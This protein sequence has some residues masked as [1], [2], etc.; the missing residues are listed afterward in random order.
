MDE[1]VSEDRGSNTGDKANET[2]CPLLACSVF[3]ILQICGALREKVKKD[4]VAAHSA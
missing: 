1:E 4:N 2:V 3:L